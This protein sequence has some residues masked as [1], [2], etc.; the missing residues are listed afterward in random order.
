[1]YDISHTHTYTPP[2][3]YVESQGEKK[4]GREREEE[5]T[6]KYLRLVPLAR[7]EFGRLNV[8]NVGL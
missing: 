8:V 2:H 1:M 7:F 4:K 3:T 5:G 6:T